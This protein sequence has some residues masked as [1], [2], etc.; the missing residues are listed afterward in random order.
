MK[1]KNSDNK[2]IF[3]YLEKIDS[4]QNL[5]EFIA[6]ATEIENTLQ[7]DIFTNIKIDNDMKDNQNNIVYFYPIT[8]MILVQIVI[9]I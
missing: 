5:N 4:S 3:Q 6:N 2:E 8:L 7:I 9:I 1:T